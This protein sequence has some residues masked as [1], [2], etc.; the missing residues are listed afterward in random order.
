MS[1]FASRIDGKAKSGTI[2]NWET[3]KNLPNNE[4]LKRIAEIGNI[5]VNELLYGDPETFIYNIIYE[6]FKKQGEI[7]QS[8]RDRYAKSKDMAHEDIT[9]STATTFL[10][11]NKQAFLKY[12]FQ[13]IQLP[14]ANSILN[15]RET[16]GRNDIHLFRN[17]FYHQPDKVK[18]AAMYAIFQ[19]LPVDITFEE[20]TIEV[21]KGLSTLPIKR[22]TGD[23][24]EIKNR[25][26]SKG[27]TEDEAYLQAVDDYYISQISTHI[28]ALQKNI[29]EVRKDYQEFIKN[30]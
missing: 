25:Y 3:G 10:E 18:H 5:D 2:S 16:H 20:F 9:S 7:W 13:Y 6:D 14:Y 23:I 11:E 28:R 30:N 15:S 26:I 1:E 8:F 24:E 17:I 29:K 19:L 12:V 21:E 22:V 27:K 4:R